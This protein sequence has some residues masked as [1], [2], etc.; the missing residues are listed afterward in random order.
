M[1]AT[2]QLQFRDGNLKVS[3]SADGQ[4][5][6]DANNELEL[7]A[8][9][10]DINASTEVNISGEMKVGGKVSTGSEGA[11]V[12]VV[13]YSNTSG[14]DFTWDASEEKLV[15]TGSNGQ[16]ALHIADGDLRVADKIYG[17]G[18]GLTGL[19]VSSITGDLTIAAE[20]NNSG[21]LTNPNMSKIWQGPYAGDGRGSSITS[22]TH[23]KIY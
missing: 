13:F 2:S 23:N 7:V 19:T 14:D 9:M 3:S 1:N 20:E 16:D 18:S 21:T 15:I 8:P 5:D 4:L 6:I 12:D 22:S 10:V 11:G 17:D